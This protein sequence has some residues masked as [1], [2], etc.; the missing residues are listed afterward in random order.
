MLNAEGDDVFMANLP[1]HQAYGL[2][3]TQFLPMIEGLPMVC[4]ADP[5]DSNGV[6]K[7]IAKYRATIL[8]GTSNLFEGYIHN[9][10]VQP[11]M[12]KSLRFAVSGL[13]DLSLNVQTAFKLKFGK[14][15]YEGY[16]TTETAPVAS[17][18]LPDVLDTSYWQ[19]QVGTKTGTVGMPL[20]GASFKVT[21]PVT[22]EELPI[23]ENGMILIGG[24]Q[25]MLG[26]L[27]S[28]EKTAEAI[29]EVDGIRWFVS[30]DKGHLDEDGFLQIT[31]QYQH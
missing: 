29:H 25:V 26:Y 13:E 21:D 20:P 23:G 11:L 14:D 15:I 28:P 3:V 2:T 1:L 31:D 16:G 4:H 12:L 9:E 10:E 24:P 5:Q 22:F 18:N 17:V 6:S 7:A 19:V 30:G 8:L 27:N